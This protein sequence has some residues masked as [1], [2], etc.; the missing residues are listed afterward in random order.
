MAQ[1]QSSQPSV[2]ADSS[3]NADIFEDYVRSRGYAASIMFDPSSIRAFW[4]DRS[5][6]VQDKTVSVFLENKTK[7]GFEGV[8][9]K[10]RLVNVNEAQDCKIDVITESQ[11]VD[12]VVMD[13]KSKVIS[14]S[15][16]EQAFSQYHV[17][18][19]SFHF[20][21]IPDNSFSLKFSS[22]TKEEIFIKRIILSFSN[23][24][25]SSFLS[26]PGR[27]ELN[28]DNVGVISAVL[29]EGSALE[30]RGKQAGIISKNY[31]LV[32]NRPVETSVRVKNVGDKP[33]HV[34]VGF[35]AY[36]KN[37]DLLKG[38]NYPYKNLN[39]VLKVVSS[40]AGSK[41][42]IVDA[43]SDW[44]RNCYLA[45]DAEEDL[46]DVPNTTLAE[47]R[48]VEVKK[49]ADGKAEITMEKPFKTALETGKKVRI[50][51]M[52][53]AYIYTNNKILQ[54][55]A[56]EVFTSSIKKDNSFLQYS[57]KAFSRGVYSVRPLIL[58]HSVDAN[59]ENTVAVSDYTVSY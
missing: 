2:P 19:S 26:P 56:E 4:D 13:S 37:K 54:P 1:A 6:L 46:F 7:N 12:F 21:N 23:N 9:L 41:S 14:K 5:V 57:S 42:I 8:P 10:I 34:Y 17:A 51:G 30:F 22:K 35:A 58:S 16:A 50:H 25:N 11:N 48:I 29:G 15:S 40:E 49:L 38:P 3:G 18:S 24:P 59:E 47:G 31:I 28:R 32:S 52:Y 55:G 44:A 36:T 53:G 27:L 39:K 43:Y 45:L 20:E 33:T